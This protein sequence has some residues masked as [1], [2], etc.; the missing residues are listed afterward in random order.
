MSSRTNNGH[1]LQS[2]VW[3]LA[4]TAVQNML[5]ILVLILLARLLAPKDFGLINISLIIIG[6]TSNFASMGV[7]TSII[8][9]KEIEPDHIKSGFVISFILGIV[10]FML[11]WL[12]A[13]QISILFD[14]VELVQVLSF[15]SISFPVLGFSTIPEA[16]LQRNMQFN[17]IVRSQLVSYVIGYCLVGITMALYGF[18]IWSLVV[19]HLLQTV[20]KSTMLCMAYRDFLKGRFSLESTKELMRFGSGATL[21]S[22]CNYAALQGDN[23]AAGIMLGPAAAGLYGRAYQVAAI[24]ATLLGQVLDKVLFSAWAKIQNEHEK[25]TKSFLDGVSL[26]TIFVLPISL[27]CVIFAP[28]IINF[29]LGSQWKEVVIPFQIL[30]MGTLFRTSYKLSNSVTMAKGAV[31]NRALRQFLYAFLV[32]AGASIGG[33]FGVAGI[34]VGVFIAITVHYL[35]TAQLALRLTNVSWNQYMRSQIAGIRFAII[36]FLFWYLLA[37]WL[38]KIALGDLYLLLVSVAASCLMVMFILVLKPTIM[39]QFGVRLNK[40]LTN[41]RSKFTR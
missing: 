6:F 11:F 39:G 41:L 30:S 16:M 14:S 40:K 7:G 3:V 4:G 10:L 13:P 2:S 21:D 37:L 9:R 26:V 31:Y 12:L 33:R 5:Q 34:A 8:Q 32:I 27:Y 15:L 17:K 19:A 25:L 22:L 35:F 24:P 38:R 18:G 28:E 36:M 20:I 23:I 29:T 1:V